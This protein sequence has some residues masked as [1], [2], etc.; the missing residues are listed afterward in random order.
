MAVRYISSPSIKLVETAPARFRSASDTC[1]HRR[2]QH[3]PT[4]SGAMKKE[5]EAEAET[6]LGT[7]AG[8]GGLKDFTRES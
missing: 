1:I 7:W 3:R 4:D 5:E 6:Y 8:A 2:F